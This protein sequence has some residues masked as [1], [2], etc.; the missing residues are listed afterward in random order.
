MKDLTKIAVL[1]VTPLVA[2]ACGGEEV[3][4]EAPEMA[5]A[6]EEVVETPSHSG[7]VFFVYPQDGAEISV[8]VPLTLEFGSENFEIS[9]V[10]EE[11]ETVRDGV[12][13]YHFG[14]D[15][16]CLPVGEIIPQSEPWVHFGDG[17]NTFD[18]PLA[19]GTYQLSV[20]AADDEHRTLEGL[21]ETISI[22][23]AD[24]I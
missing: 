17:S 13:H 10:P 23:I 15:T 9:P 7:R 21:C 14:F 2:G 4:S 24:G 3:M 19:P 11:L 12:G 20:Q 8:D 5:E 18:L 22:E 6:V 1:L 16:E